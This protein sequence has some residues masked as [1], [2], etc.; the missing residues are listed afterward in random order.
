MFRHI[1]LYLI[2]CCISLCRCYIH[3]I[4]FNC[5][6]NVIIWLL[7]Q[8]GQKNNCLHMARLFNKKPIQL[9]L[10]KGMVERTFSQN[11]SG[12][13]PAKGLI[14]LYSS[15]NIILPKVAIY[16]KMSIQGAFIFLMTSIILLPFY[17]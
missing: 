6:I 13:E 12:I 9:I 5:D 2:I 16:I 8:L 15:Y 11:T 3:I 10:Y 17:M 4:K 1:L 14:A 7:F